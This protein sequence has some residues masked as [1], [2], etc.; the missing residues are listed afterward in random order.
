[1]DHTVKQVFVPSSTL[2]TTGDTTALTTY[3]MGFYDPANH[4]AYA[5]A[6][7][8]EKFFLA[9]ASG[10]DKYGSFQTSVVTQANVISFTGTAP[11]TAATQQITYV[12]FDEVEQSKS[13]TLRC[14]EEYFLTIRIK[15][16]YSSG[17]F[18]PLIQDSV[19]I[20][21]ACCADCATN[22][23]SLN[24]S[25]YFQKAVDDINDNP[26]LS[27]YVTAS[28]VTSCTGDAAETVFALTMTD[29]GTN[30]GG[31]SEFTFT[32][33]DAA[34]YTD[35]TY[36]GLTGTASASGTGATFT[37]VV[38]SNEITSLTLTAA[39]SGYVMG[40]TITITTGITGQSS[41][42]VVVTVTTTTGAEGAL[43]EAIQDFY[44]DKVDD[45]DTDIVITADT[46][47]D[48]D[49]GSTGNIRIELTPSAG[50]SLAD[51]QPYNGIEWEE[52]TLDAGSESC[53]CGI[54]LVGNA[55][56]EFGNT[57][58]PDAVPHIA[59][60]VQF[61]AYVHPGPNTTMDFDL[62]DFCNAWNVTTTQEIEFPKGT[63]SQMAEF[64]RHYFRNNLANVQERGFYWSPI[65]N[66]DS[67]EFL[68]VD[69]AKTYFQYSL[70]YFEPSNK[71]FKV[72]HEEIHEIHILVDATNT[73]LANSI[74]SFLSTFTGITVDVA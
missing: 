42:D 72:Q 29:P 68:L 65:Y 54:K 53:S 1:M 71:G 56:D 25:D 70:K 2:K 28:L 3:Q 38:L 37:A 51:M 69:T 74:E 60:L 32:Y 64:E 22:C 40:E 47:G 63:G 66:N 26:L 36:T 39:G 44:S 73:T 43:L 52:I 21:T 17:V 10:N 16:S 7:G 45:V 49:S 18:Q 5:S 27:K 41:E 46:D 6:S 62:E 50:V 34:T 13:P 59:N 20:K 48:Q 30:V 15:E 12:G 55:L 57:C 33:P 14:D 11:D 24:C 58:V 31:A 35:G 61:K 23:D 19:R 8:V 4:T 67:N 9:F